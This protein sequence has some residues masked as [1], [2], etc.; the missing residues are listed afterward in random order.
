MRNYVNKTFS[1]NLPHCKNLINVGC[2]HYNQPFIQGLHA[3][4]ALYQSLSSASSQPSWA[5]RYIYVSTK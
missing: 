3:K 2:H 1:M 4:V 5:A